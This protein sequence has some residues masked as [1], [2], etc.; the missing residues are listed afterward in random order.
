VTTLRYVCMICGAGWDN[1]WTEEHY[2]P[3]ANDRWG[4]N[5]CV[6]VDEDWKRGDDQHFEIKGILTLQKLRADLA[7]G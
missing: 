5:Y 4:W 6:A 3:C 2:W 1:G 7:G